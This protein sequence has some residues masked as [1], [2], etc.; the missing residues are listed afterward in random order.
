[1]LLIVVKIESSGD[2]VQIF[3][4]IRI[5]ASV[6]TTEHSPQLARLVRSPQTGL[7]FFANAC[8]SLLLLKILITKVIAPDGQQ[9]PQVWFDARK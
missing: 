8:F 5:M 2:A 7:G 4:V 3:E 1:L 6:P 9:R